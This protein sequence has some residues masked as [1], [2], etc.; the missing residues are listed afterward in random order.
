[1]FEAEFFMFFV[2]V[3]FVAIFVI[4]LILSAP[5][6]FVW[7]CFL[8]KRIGLLEEQNNLLRTTLK[9]QSNLPS[10]QTTTSATESTESTEPTD[11]TT[12]RWSQTIPWIKTTPTSAAQLDPAQLD[13]AQ[14]ESI[15]SEPTQPEPTELEHEPTQ[16]T[17]VD[18]ITPLQPPPVEPPPV[19][20]PRTDEEW[21][22]TLPVTPTDNGNFAWQSLEL[23]IGRKL[24]GWIAV[25]GFIVSAALFIRHAVQSGWIGPEM[26]V[27]GIAVFGTAFL[28]AGKYF[29][30]IGWQRFSTMLSSAGIIIVFQAGYASFAFYK[31]IT[32]STAGVVM[33]FIICGSF[34][35]AWHY[36]SKLLGVISIL[37]GLAVP[38]L[39]STGNDR[40]PEFFTYLIILNIGT[41]ILVNLLRRASIGFIAFWGT[42]IEFWL[43]YS[44]YYYPLNSIL[45]EKLV[46]VLIFQGLFYLA[47]LIDTTIA[48]MIPR[49]YA[50]P[51]WDDAMR[52]ILAPILFFG[53]IWQLL[54]NELTLGSWLGV[55]AF[56]GAL[57]YGLL[58][59]LYSKHLARI[60][61][62]E[63]DQKLSVYWK[64]APSAATVI[65]LGFVAIGIP[66]H[67]DAAWLALGWCTVFAGLWYFGHRQEN[68]TFRVMAIGF[69]ILGIGR[70]L[71]DIFELG[72]ISNAVLPLTKFPVTTFFDLP[73][74]AAIFIA[75]IAVILTDRLIAAKNK[76]K[77]K[78]PYRRFNFWIGVGGYVFL[79][80][81]LSAELL[82]YFSLRT[83]IY[84]PHIYWASLSLT[85]LWSLLVLL[86]LQIGL[87]FR[88]QLLRQ[89]ALFH[90]AIVVVKMFA[91]F[92]AREYFLEPITN[93]F[94]PIMIFASFVLIA[95]GVQSQFD[96]RFTEEKTIAG[97]LGVVGIFSL[98]GVLSIE[99][100]QFFLRSPLSLLL[101]LPLLIP[102]ETINDAVTRSFAL[103]M[104][105]IL[106]TC[107]AVILL[108]LGILFQ[109]KILRGCGLIVLFGTLIKI[110][111]IELFQRPDYSVSFLN[112]YFVTMLV[113]VLTVMLAGVWMIR[114]RP[115][116]DKTERDAFLVTSLSGIM[117]LWV[118]LSV[119][120]FTYFVKNPFLIE[121]ADQTMQTFI[122]TVSLSVLWTLCAGVL[123]VVGVKCRSVWLRGFG[124]LIFAATITKIIA[125][126]LFHRPAFEI[127]LLN[128]YFIAIFVASAV[129]IAVSVWNTRLRPLTDQRER[130]SFFVFGILGIG[131]LWA[132]LSVECFDYFKIRIDL[133]NNQFLATISLTVF[134]TISAIIIAIIAA[135][136]RSRPL[137]ILSV[138]LLLV[139]L[140][141]VC[142][143]E[144]LTRPDYLTLFLNPYSVPLNLLAFALIFV[145]V[146]LISQLNE[147]DSEER[148]V[149]R[150]FMFSGVVFLWL[151]L[152]LECF[153][154]VRLLQGAESE[155]WKAQM[156][157]SILWSV[158]A[159]VL[160][161]VGF[162]WR[163]SVLRWMAI[164]LFAVTLTKVL[165][166]DMAGVHE[167]YRFG[168]VFVLAIFLALAAW[169]YQRFKPEQNSNK[170]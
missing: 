47:Y 129:M 38:M 151:V 37:G 137:R 48:A 140:L 2:L 118:F 89:V 80:L 76:N 53:T 36:G 51:T 55:V 14:P 168:A 54:H 56:I 131:L 115:A 77:N 121:Q 169:A 21:E 101:S 99:C 91:D 112:P 148:D 24:L 104:L 135:T 60:W 114:I 71:H 49:S 133:P 9:Q 30:Q 102:S 58:T 10:N 59:V 160:I 116:N 3:I 43:W 111:L 64:A 20:K 72:K 134:W 153:K 138:G 150:L 93:P 83:E 74:F 35:L 25:L 81:F 92:F 95:V 31:L 166:V 29:W 127:P 170:S 110:A 90:F 79:T 33:P 161:F 139:T 128:P 42:Q 159:G 23:W 87:V 141:K 147:N 11:P 69:M 17:P 107:Y 52:A 5:I 12:T 144:L 70:L 164:L 155:A 157:L 28:V 84:D 1:M 39:L 96:K 67:F 124:L 32:V 8:S 73:S 4:V 78:E 136:S 16:P 34:L 105:S 57:W 145:C 103:G 100:Y 154:T 163:S 85:A 132:A 165:F 94:C 119:E 65:A 18:L 22:K 66:L 26:K 63:V 88:S 152:S 98:L 19:K 123:I 143:T 106:W 109:S 50:Q 27:L 82:Q 6:A 97:V 68:K 113:P 15:Q 7:C 75:I 108:V 44:E 142:F 86:L 61:D 167:L 126:V 156:S 41:I 62:V 46:A 45:S 125:L 120:C 146:F 117:L 162:V 13:P 122:A 40:Y 130:N 149:Y 158:F